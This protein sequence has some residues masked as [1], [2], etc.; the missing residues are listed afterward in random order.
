MRCRRRGRGCGRATDSC[1]R[2]RSAA[3]R[4][5]VP[6]SAA[7]CRGVPR[8][9]APRRPGSV[10]GNSRLSDG[11][12]EDLR[13]RAL[14]SLPATHLH[15]PPDRSRAVASR[16]ESPSPGGTCEPGS[17]HGQ[18]RCRCRSSDVGRRA[19]ASDAWRERRS[20]DARSGSRVAPRRHRGRTRAFRA[21]ES[22]EGDRPA[23]T[24]HRTSASA[25][26]LRGLQDRARHSVAAPGDARLCTPGPT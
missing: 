20:A 16:R 6:R 3:E 11:G 12:M 24:T 25:R 17:G 8:S 18:G 14:P 7:E 13:N 26:R 5:G 1:S 22:A 21:V 15:E 10:F 4:R 2:Q 19:T 23:G 9:G